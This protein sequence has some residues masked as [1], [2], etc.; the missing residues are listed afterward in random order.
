MHSQFEICS[1]Y[2][3]ERFSNMVYT[4]KTV[5]Q[6]QTSSYSEVVSIELC[7]G[8]EAVADV[9][10]GKVR[11]EREKDLDAEHCETFGAESSPTQHPTS[12]STAD[13]LTKSF[14]PVSTSLDKDLIAIPIFEEQESSFSLGA[15]TAIS[16]IEEGVREII[17]GKASK[18]GQKML[19]SPRID[20][21]VE[22]MGSQAPAL[23][24]LDRNQAGIV[25]FQPGAV[26][27]PGMQT[28]S[29][30][31]P[32]LLV[33]AQLV[34]DIEQGSTPISPPMEVVNAEPMK[35]TSAS[36][37]GLKDFLHSRSIQLFLILFCLI[38]FGVIAGVALE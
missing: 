10:N 19:Q 11:M 33:N 26:A 32:S 6:E 18:Q 12:T 4:K 9:I 14:V 22:S 25:I 28:S 13:Q 8:D 17:T 2:N 31:D 1:Q 35:D 15:T 16:S 30:S 34:L 24:S 5:L 3:S 29:S 38:M 23:T 21:D 37:P 20:G 27:V 7:R 36:Q